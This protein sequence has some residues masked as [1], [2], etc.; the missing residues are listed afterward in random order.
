M[1]TSKK[2]TKPAPR[3]IRAASR[4][5]A[6]R[7]RSHALA[8]EH[9]GERASLAL[10]VM[11]VGGIAVLISAVA[12]LVSGFTMPNRYAT[13]A[14]P[15]LGQ[16]GVG[17]VLGGAAVLV[18]ALAIVAAVAGTFLDLRGARRMAVILGVLTAASA[19]A[20]V[21]A[22]MTIGG[23]DQPLALVLLVVGILFAAA[24]AIL[25]RTRRPLPAE[26]A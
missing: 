13:S 25:G 18:L 14:P 2:V 15:N 1:V 24:S 21:V 4:S 9:L 7:H 12:V 3:M 17:Q 6:T 19:A 8:P 22:V 5:V 10:L 26:P 23:G 20:G 11:A 16:L